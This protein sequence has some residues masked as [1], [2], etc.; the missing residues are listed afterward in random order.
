MLSC[1]EWFGACQD[2]DYESQADD[3][4]EP[5]TLLFTIHHL[6]RKESQVDD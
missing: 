6:L 5:P 3:K 4:I 1:N 2:D